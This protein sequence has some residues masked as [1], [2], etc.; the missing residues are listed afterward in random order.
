ML[1]VVKWIIGGLALLTHPTLFAMGCDNAHGPDSK[2][3]FAS[4]SSEKEVLA[5]LCFCFPPAAG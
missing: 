4:F 3:L 2:S 1:A 5:L